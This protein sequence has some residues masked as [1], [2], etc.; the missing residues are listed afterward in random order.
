MTTVAGLRCRLI[1]AADVTGI[2]SHRH[3]GSRQ[4]EV[5]LIVIESPAGPTHG[6]VALAALFSELS[7]VHIIGF[8]AADAGR[9][10]LGPRNARL[11]ATVAR[12]R[13]MCALECE[14]GQVMSEL[15]A[16][17]LHDVGRAALVFRMASA[18]FTDTGVGHAAVEPNSF[19]HIG[20]DFLVTVQTQRG[21]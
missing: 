9:R 2:T 21:L 12:Q 7:A 17:E 6:A 11:V 19:P 13:R 18:A 14:V 3:V 5:R 1:A 8:V 15:L 4:F 10:S 16:A 20:R